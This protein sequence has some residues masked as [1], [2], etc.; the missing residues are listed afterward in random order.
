MTLKLPEFIAEIGVNHGGDLS[1]AHQYLDTLA[2][3]GCTV[4]KFQTYKAEKLVTQDA[5][6][7][8]DTDSEAT[9]KQIDLFRK[10]DALSI[11]NYKELASH[12]RDLGLE[13]MTT[14][15]DVDSLIELS[16]SL[17]RIKIAS[18]DITNFQ[19]LIEASKLNK[20]ILLSTGAASFVEIGQALEV[21]SGSSQKILL[22]HC[23][24]NYPTDFEN[25]NLGRIKD[26]RKSFPGFGIG[27]SDHTKPTNNHEVQIAAWLTGA[28]VIEK[29]FTLDKN[30]IGN[31][32]YHSYDSKDLISFIAATKKISQ[33]MAYSEE[34]FLSLQLAARKEARRGIYFTRDIAAGT[35]IGSGD[36]ISLRPVGITPASDYLEYFGR[37]LSSNVTKGHQPEPQ[38]F[39]Q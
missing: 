15:F 13:F 36:L 27:Y 17:D 31:D 3:S 39:R 30:L 32:H 25:A 4:A 38:D 5:K 28:E 22:L 19:L 11:D 14:C 2:A 18:A 23:V 8:W 7:Y 33:M 10:Y 9:Q 24:L 29:H 26:L 12:C 35:E 16:S 34:H 1:L 21:L 6:A 37:T 20:P